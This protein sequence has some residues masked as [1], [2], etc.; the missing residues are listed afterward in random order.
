ML[1]SSA[2][3]DLVFREAVLASFLGV[4]ASLFAVAVLFGLEWMGLVG[5]VVALLGGIARTVIVIQRSRVEKE[6]EVDRLARRTLVPIEPISSVDMTKVGV[7]AAAP[8]IFSKKEV[9]E[10]LSRQVDGELHEAVSA[11]LDGNGPRIVMVVG[12]SKVG[13]SRTLFEALRACAG[14]AGLDFIAPVDGA[15]L[16]SLLTPGEIPPTDGG[17]AV[18]WLDDIEPFINEG[19]TL[20]TLLDWQ[21]KVPGRSVIA[22]TY[23]G[24]GS[25]RLQG[26]TPA[27]VSTVAG[28]ISR[29]ARQVVLEATSDRELAPIRSRL[30]DNVVRS[31]QKHGLAAYLVAATELWLKLHSH[32]HSAGEPE[33]PEGM[34]VV[35]ATVDWARC[36]RTDPLPERTL[37][38]MLWPGYL[39]GAQP[40]AAGF[41]AGVKW[42]VQRV[43]GSI[44]LIEDVGGYRAYDYVVDLI[45][46]DS[47]EP[48]PKDEVWDVAIDGASDAQALAV[49][50][51]AHFAGR[52]PK[53]VE[54][55][56]IATRSPIDTNAAIAGLNLGIA[57]HQL[58]RS[59]EE[60]SAYDEVLA[61]FG[62][63]EDP[64]LC[65]AVAGAMVNKA[66]QLGAL[67][68]PEEAISLFDEV[69]TRFG[70]AAESTPLFRE[71]IAIALLNKGVTLRVDRHE[72]AIAA[73]DEVLTRFGDSAEL[74]VRRVISKVLVNKGTSLGELNRL[75][76]EISVYDEVLAR[77][78]DDEELEV[79][80]QVATALGNKSVRLKGLGRPDEAIALYDE[81][82]ARFG[83]AEELVLREMVAGALVEKGAR[84]GQLG[85]PDEAI[86]LYDEVLARFGDAEELALRVVIATALVNKGM[87]L[88]ELDPR[89]VEEAMSCHDEVV[90]R[91]GDAEEIALGEQVAKALVNKAI[92]LGLLDRYEEAVSLYSEVVARFGD[93]EEPAL[94]RVVA[95]ALANKGVSLRRLKDHEGEVSFY[96]EVLAR[97]GDS[98][99]PALREVVDSALRR[100]GGVA[101]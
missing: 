71:R 2:L 29:R 99:D 37:R 8:T 35:K 72:E 25:D 20:R 51:N 23:G 61:R 46:N 81:V 58:E 77:F 69:L 40:T 24:K 33:S 64:V 12:R 47:K 17:G 100:T 74:A 70:D 55:F 88:G 28:E 31:V 15:A 67:G 97:F 57:L 1:R 45:A 91:F 30:P 13:K 78:G 27:S 85:R 68:R 18:L 34:A 26:S 79:R 43:A 38:E 44:S 80:E 60:I 16:E 101:S 83:D 93:V 54:A 96:K 48:A 5:A 56:R 19:V 42:A 50:V 76:E 49:G 73:Y 62:D 4:A 92:R 86:A 21:G 75:E 95:T 22:T 36:G 65:E 6:R 9:P 89:E 84:L 41:E 11:G 32:R 53:A 94:R 90:A 3:K 52:Y 82:L 63:S 87:T 98:E 59:E 7:D 66:T 10:Y 14:G 39:S